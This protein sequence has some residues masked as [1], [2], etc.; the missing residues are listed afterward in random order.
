MDLK[1]RVK[2]LSLIVSFLL[3]SCGTRVYTSGTYGSI[4]SYTA[5]PEFRGENKKATYVSV[6]ISKG[7]QRIDES[8][9]DSK[10]LVSIN[11]HRSITR[12]YFNFYYGLGGTI[13]NYKFDAPINNDVNSDSKSFYSFN[14]KTGINLNLPTKKVDWR[15]LGLELTY[16]YEFGPYQD[17]LEQVKNNNE[18]PSLLVF[19]E[20]SILAYNIGTEA[21]FKLNSGNAFSLGVYVG[22]IL[23]RTA[24]L[25]DRNTMF[26]GVL[27]SY[28]IKKFTVSFLREEGQEDIASSKFGLTYELF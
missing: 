15:I 11:A 4:K 10:T 18:D 19:N 7:K 13:G 17:I 16:N 5:K 3:T 14:S 24:D 6:D 12:K 22:E 2:L 23:N 20:K 26:G 9:T 8:I 27:M 21:V 25:K 1:K 28:K